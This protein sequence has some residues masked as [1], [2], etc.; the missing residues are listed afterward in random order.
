[1]NID[2]WEMEKDAKEKKKEKEV[3]YEQKLFIDI[4]MKEILLYQ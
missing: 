1:M 3:R 2:R 4:Q